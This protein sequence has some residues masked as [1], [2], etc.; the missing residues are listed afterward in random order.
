MN[1]I[2]IKLLMNE[3]KIIQLS[4]N[5]N[6]NEYYMKIV[7]QSD[8]KGTLNDI[9]DLIYKDLHGNKTLL[10]YTT[11]TNPQENGKISL[12]NISVRFD[13]SILIYEGKRI[14]RA[15]IN[16]KVLVERN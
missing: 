14:Y 11:Y 5:R 2:S 10:D 7:C 13:P 6:D 9:V 3:S 16:F 8:R 12:I 15:D 4:S 1:T